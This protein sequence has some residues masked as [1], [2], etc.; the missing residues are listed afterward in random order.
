VFNSYCMFIGS[1]KNLGIEDYEEPGANPKHTPPGHPP[2]S[3]F[4]NVF[5]STYSLTRRSF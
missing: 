3:M 4:D 1:E 5:I 2:P